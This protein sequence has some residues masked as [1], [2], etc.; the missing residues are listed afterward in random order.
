LS[1]SI[2]EENILKHSKQHYS[3]IHVIEPEEM[4]SEMKV[5]VKDN[6]HVISSEK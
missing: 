6:I 5:E 3:K 2:R 4:S 1:A